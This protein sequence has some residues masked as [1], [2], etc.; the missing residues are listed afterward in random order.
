MTYADN[1]LNQTAIRQFISARNSDF[2]VT[3]NFNRDTNIESARNALKSG[4][5]RID[6]RLVGKHWSKKPVEERIFFY[7]APEHIH[8]NLHWHIMLSVPD[9]DK[10][11]HFKWIAAN[12][13]K[14]LVPSGSM[15]IQLITSAADNAKASSYV[16][17]E[18]WR[19]ENIDAFLISTE[20][21]GI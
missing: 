21:S 13:W 10:K 6:R 8:S 5:A 9:E 14:Q 16:A 4:G 15:D 11:K 18:L 1:K 3:A 2:F 19:Q 17:K 12:Y 7:A 20:F